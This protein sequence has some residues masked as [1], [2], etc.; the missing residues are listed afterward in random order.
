MRDALLRDLSSLDYIVST[1]VDARLNLPEHC[2]ECV[3]VQADDDVWQIWRE[4]ISLVDA[5][6]LI[7]PETDGL[8][9]YLT[10]IATMEGK[11]IL[12]CGLTSV[13]VTSDKM[14]TYLALEAAGFA[15]IPTYTFEYW[16]KSH[17][18]WL[19]KPND[20]AGCSDTACF[21]NADTMQD[22]IERNKKQHTHVI[23]PFQPGKSASISC[24]MH[25]GKAQ[26][27]SCNTQKI[28]IVNH[29]LS[30][31][32]G[33]INGM[34]D[35]W[36]QFELLANNIAQAFPDLA[37]YVG[38]DVIVDVDEYLEHSEIHIVEINP[39]FTTSYIG[40]REAIGANPIELIINMLTNSNFEWPKL[41]QN[42]VQIDV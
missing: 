10:Q 29:M 7:A 37:G 41:Q 28:E 18:I 14:A 40:L 1:T 19:A 33:V 39:R 3:E 23:Q 32:G 15:V 2:A 26:L 16:P 4:Q 42:Q 17:W 31:K 12:G 35:H 11:L 27:L 5:V 9:H 30:Y 24:V 36:T 38:I 25:R 34:R 22:W 21:N 8:L 13:K 6:F 20:G